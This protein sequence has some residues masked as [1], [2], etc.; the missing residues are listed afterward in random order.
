[1]TTGRIPRR[2]SRSC[3]PAFRVPE[4]PGGRER[5]RRERSF[6]RP[7]L[8]YG[9]VL[10]AD[11]IFLMAWGGMAVHRRLERCRGIEVLA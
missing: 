1:M 10:L 3:S 7:P 2:S 9:P 6:G 8:H 11:D 5:P 4:L